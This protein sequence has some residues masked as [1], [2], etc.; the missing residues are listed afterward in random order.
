MPVYQGAA[1]HPAFSKCYVGTQRYRK[2]YDGTTLVWSDTLIHD[3]FDWDGWLQGWINELCAADDLGELIS[4]GYGMIVDGLGNV[5]GSTVA[6]IQDGVNETGKLVANAGT[7]LVDAYCGAWGGSAPPDGLI[8][9]VNGIPIIGGILADWLAGDID[10]ESIIG[11]LP[12]IG[13]IAK[14]IGLLPDSA[15][16]LLDPL[17]Y[18]IDELGNVVGTITCGKYTN[19][20]GGIGENI[21]YVIGVVEQAARMLVPDGLMSLDRQVSWVRHPTV[22]T[23]DDG[24]VETQIANVGS[25]GFSTQV[26]RRYANDG[27]RARGVG[28]DFTDSAA[29]IVRRVGGTNTLVAPNLA[30]FTEGDVLRLEQAGNLH[31]LLKN[32]NDVGEWPDTGGTAA[33][34]ASN[35]SVGMFMEGAKE[36]LGSRRFGPALNYLDAG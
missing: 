21:C 20:G 11:S 19:I 7:S 29:S 33:T 34:G 13:N 2:I 36:F 25:P 22:L 10:I 26:F 30:R 32:G 1:N 5:V 28:M 14:Q 18:V 23:T 27:S 8:G 12:V 35:R 24:W 9:L 17:N 31:V 3:G 16:H 15:G 6:Y 4:D